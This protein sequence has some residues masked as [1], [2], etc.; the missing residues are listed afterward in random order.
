MNE[1]DRREIDQY[2]TLSK[3]DPAVRCRANAI[4]LGGSRTTA[5]STTPTPVPSWMRSPASTDV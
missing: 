4:A 2:A 5:R 3:L 1:S